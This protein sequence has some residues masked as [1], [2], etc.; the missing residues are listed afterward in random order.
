[1]LVSYRVG[2]GNRRGFTLIELLVVIA[3]IGIL[4]SLLLPA[5]Q[6]ARAAA[7][8]IQCQNHL[9]QIALATHHYHDSLNYL[10]MATHWGGKYYSAFTAVLPYLEQSPLFDTY[11]TRLSAFDPANNSVVG[12]KVTTYL[13]PS[14]VLARQV[15]SSSCGEIAAPASYAVNTGSLSAWGP[16][17]NGAIVGHD[18]GRTGFRDILD[19]TSNTLLVGELDYG[20]K[21]YNFTSGPCTGAYRG[22]VSAWAI[23]YPGYSMATTFGVYNSDRLITGFNEYQTFRSDHENGC[24]F[25]LADGSIRFISE[26][27]DESLLDALATRAG[28]E[29]VSEY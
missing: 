29:P 8:R 21:N 23:G 6:A 15:P 10:P 22:G 13:C 26:I 1:M 2:C 7:R 3:I 19:G 14:M 28:G 27:I 25:A 11:D 9:K 4:V 12:Q 20:L 24:N 18:K 17:H 5:V 16:I